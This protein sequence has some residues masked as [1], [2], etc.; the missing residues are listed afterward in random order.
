M[1]LA[2]PPPGGPTWANVVK[3]DEKGS[4]VNLASYL[5]LDCFKKECDVVLIVSNDSDLAEPLRIVK[6]E[7]GIKI[8]VTQPRVGSPSVTLR[9]EAHFVRPIRMGALASSQFSA[10]LVDANGT[11]T[12]PSSW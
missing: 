10:T 2:N 6:R 7:F 12:K 9:S 11:F 3:T 4:D 8:G 5:L 1:R